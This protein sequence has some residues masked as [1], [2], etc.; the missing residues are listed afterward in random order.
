MR[1]FIHDHFI[2]IV[3]GVLVLLIG[4]VIFATIYESKDCEDRGGERIGTGRYTTTY[5]MSGK[6]LIPFTSEVMECSVD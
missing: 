2:K 4:L 3:I 6:V 1:D 5:V